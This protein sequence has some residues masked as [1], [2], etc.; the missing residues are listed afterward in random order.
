MTLLLLLLLFCGHSDAGYGGN[1]LFT[2]MEAMRKLWVEEKV[3]VQKLQDIVN[4]I[5]DAIPVMEK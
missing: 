4:N 2:S 5:K 3:F 1:D